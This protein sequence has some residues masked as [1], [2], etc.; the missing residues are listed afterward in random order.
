M[1]FLNEPSEYALNRKSV[2]KIIRCHTA[3]PDRVFTD[4]FGHFQFIT[5]DE[6]LMRQFLL[7]TRA[8]LQAIDECTFQFSV[9][10]PD[11]KQYYFK[12][13][14]Y[15]VLNISSTDTDED[16][17]AAL[18]AGPDDSP[19]DALMHNTNSVLLHS[20]SCCWA[21]YAEQELGVGVC[22]FTDKAISDIFSKVYSI[23]FPRNIDSTIKLMG[24]VFKNGKVPMDIERAFRSS[25]SA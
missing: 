13:S 22:A 24:C 5:F 21:V 17:M 8:F 18:N 16:Y 25:Y 9:I 12:H 1:R 14:K 15:S 11:P 2:S 23:D 7:N 3:F 4:H 10:D 19:A 6:I 20:S